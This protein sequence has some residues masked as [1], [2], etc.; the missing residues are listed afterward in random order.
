MDKADPLKTVRDLFELPEGVIYLDG[1][2]LGARPKVVLDALLKTARDEWG[3]DLIRSWNSHDWINLPQT[4][5]ELIAPI[6]G[7]APGQVI[8]ADSIDNPLHGVLDI[9]DLSRPRSDL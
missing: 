3:Q 5:G 7:A 9:F 1:N 8:C 6:I 2:S 4:T